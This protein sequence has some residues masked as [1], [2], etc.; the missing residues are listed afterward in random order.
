[1]KMEVAHEGTTSVIHISVARI[2][3]A[4]MRC[5]M[6]VRPSMPNTPAGRFQMINVITDRM[7][8]VIMRLFTDDS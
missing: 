1:M 3:M 5:W 4:M 6:T 7:S 8:A 2:K